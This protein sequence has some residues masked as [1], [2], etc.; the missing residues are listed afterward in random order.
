MSAS[1]SRITNPRTLAG[2][3]IASGFGECWLDACFVFSSMESSQVYVS[4]Y[5]VEFGPFAPHE[6]IRLFERRVFFPTD[7]IRESGSNHWT[8]ARE[9]RRGPKPDARRPPGVRIVG[10]NWPQGGTGR[11]P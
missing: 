10:G 9:W 1:A 4:R 5:H 3:P 11:A 8:P 7:Y 6:V 2:G